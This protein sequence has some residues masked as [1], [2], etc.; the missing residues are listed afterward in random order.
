MPLIIIAHEPQMP[1]RQSWSNAIGSLPLLDQPLV[2]HVEHLEERHV[3]G[4]VGRPGRSPSGRGSCRSFC[5]QTWRVSF[6]VIVGS[7]CQASG[8]QSRLTL[9]VADAYL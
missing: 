6:M 9:S 2:D 3:R 1:S 7:R 8:S 4:D 5:R